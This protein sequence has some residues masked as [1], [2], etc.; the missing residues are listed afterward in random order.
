M[1]SLFVF[2]KRIESSFYFLYNFHNTRCGNDQLLKG[3]KFMNLEKEHDL[4]PIWSEFNPVTKVLTDISYT[5]N[6]CS[7]VMC[8][9]VHFRHDPTNMHVYFTTMQLVLQHKEFLCDEQRPLNNPF[10]QPVPTHLTC[11]KNYV[12]SGTSCKPSQQT[13]SSVY[14]IG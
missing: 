1:W 10:H 2:P 11:T 14:L 9:C 12:L 8:W 13:Y 5:S 7:A 6:S 4:D 3:G